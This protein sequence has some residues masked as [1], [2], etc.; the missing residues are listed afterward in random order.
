MSRT[1]TIK[2]ANNRD[3]ELHAELYNTAKERTEGRGDGRISDEDARAL[4]AI[5]AKDNAYSDLE[6]KTM[7]YIRKNFSFTVKGDAT[8]RELVRTA[9]AK[10]WNPDDVET[11][12]FTAGN[13]H[14]VTVIAS[15]WAEAQLRTAGRGD[16]RLGAEDAE[17]LFELVAAD[18][19]YSDLE[20]KTVRFIRKN[21]KWTDKGDETFRNLIRTSA[22][23]GWSQDDI[24]G[25]LAD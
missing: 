19:T 22:S 18:N 20:K 9:A 13:G 7:K 2:A 3:V 15:L 5:V 21:F 17:A 14:E 24:D 12:T 1:I 10:G 25:V 23:K 11:S 16:G 8:F 4:F 6:K